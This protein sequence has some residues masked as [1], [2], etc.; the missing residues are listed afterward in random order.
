M[1][2]DLRHL[3]TFGE[4]DPPQRLLMGPGPVN[5]HPRVLRAMAADLLGQFDPEMTTYMNEVMALYRPLFG[6]QNRWTF[7]VD[8]TARAGIEAALVSLVQPGDR[9]LVINFGRFGLLLTEILGRLGADVHTVDA[10][11]GEVVPLAAIAEAIARVAPKLVATVHG[12]TSTTMAQPLDGLGALCRAAGALSYV[13]A[14]ATIG[15][16]DIASDRWEVDVVTA[17]L[18]KCLGGP[19]GSAPITVSAAAAEA[20]FARRHVERGIVREDIANGSGPRIAS[21][22]FDLAMIMG[23]WSDKRLNHHTE[24]TTMLYGARECARVALQEGL[25][26]RYA[27]H[28]AAGR[29]VSAGVRALGL[30]VFG[31]DA[32]RMSNVTGVVIP[33]GVDSEAVRRRMREDFE[34]EIGTAFGPLQGR[35]WRIGAMGYNAMKHKVLLT[36][37][38]LEAVLR[39]EGYA[40]TQG[41]AVEA[42]R[43]A[44]HAEPAA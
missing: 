18:Q 12:D 27:R 33:H 8:G 35:I 16:M 10:P 36:L 41:L 19:S 20:I 2:P 21:N 15:G 17:G 23:Y 37:A 32:H 29:A 42:A 14:T 1:A 4:L 22:Y 39:A 31:D 44:W 28:A 3:H 30:E 26:T 13:D 6:T 7:L 11:W 38:A 9:V 24:A 25:E 5:A 43:A 34:I 40:C